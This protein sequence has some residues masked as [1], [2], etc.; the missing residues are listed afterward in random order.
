LLV[1]VALVQ[2]TMDLQQVELVDQVVVVQVVIDLVVEQLELQE[3]MDVLILV[4]V[5]ADLVVV[6]LMLQQEQ[7]DQDESS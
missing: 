1:V 4:V 3:R 5:G 6:Q 7:A 2:K